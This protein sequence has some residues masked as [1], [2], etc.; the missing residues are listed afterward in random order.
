MAEPFL[1]FSGCP[2]HARARWWRPWRATNAHT[3]SLTP[4]LTP[5]SSPYFQDDVAVD[6]TGI[7]RPVELA[8]AVV[9][10]WAEHGA[11]GVGAVADD[12]QVVLDQPLRHR[13]YGTK[14]D[15][16]ALAPDPKVHHALAALD[17]PDP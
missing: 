8:R 12:R 17:V 13:M 7:E 2:P 5:V 6:R 15:L 4:A 3:T 10:H 14:P 9:G 16:A 1:D 11:F